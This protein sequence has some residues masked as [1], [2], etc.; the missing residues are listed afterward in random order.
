[1]AIIYTYPITELLTTDDTV[2]ITDSSSTNKA[3]R[4]ATIGQINALGPQGDITNV[5]LTMPDGFT[6]TPNKSNGVVTLDVT[7]RPAGLGP[8]GTGSQ[9]QFAAADPPGS[10][11]FVFD[12][13]PGL[14]VDISTTRTRLDVG[15]RLNPTGRGEINIHSGERNI[16]YT[17]GGVLDLEYAYPTSQPVFQN[18]LATAFVGL[19]G[20]EYDDNLVP[21]DPLA[22]Y[23][24][25][26]YNIQLPVVT[27]A[28]NTQTNYTDAR[29]LVV[30]ATTT[31][32][33]PVHQSKWISPIDSITEKIN[34]PGHSPGGR[35]QLTIG[36]PALT[37]NEP[38]G[39]I[40]LNG[41]NNSDEGGIIRLASA[42]NNTVGIAGPQ[43]SPSP[44]TDYNYDFSLPTKSPEQTDVV[45]NQGVR[46]VQV[47]AG[48][49]E[50]VVGTGRISTS[51]GTGSGCTINI[52]GVDTGI[53]TSVSIVQ[54]GEGYSEGDILT[55]DLPNHPGDAATIEVI[56]INGYKNK[57]LVASEERAFGPSQDKLYET[58]WVDPMEL[59][60]TGTPA[61]IAT[62]IQ[63]NAGNDQFGASSEFTYLAG[64]AAEPAERIRLG[65]GGGGASGYPGRLEIFGENA[66]NG[67]AGAL[68]LYCTNSNH[69][70]QL[71]GMQHTNAVSYDI[72]FPTTGPANS[73]QILQTNAS[74]ELAW[75]NTPS[76]G[77][78]TVEK[79][80][81]N[82]V[83][84]V[85]TINFTGGGVSVGDAGNGK[86]NVEVLPRLSQGWS[87]FPI[88]Q[89]E[90]FITVPS[91]ESKTFIQQTVCDVAAGVMEAIKIYKTGGDVQTVVSA[92]VYL[93]K[94]RDAAN[95][96]LKAYGTK[97]DSGG[98][99]G[100][101][102]IKLDDATNNNPPPATLNDWSPV[103][104]TPCIVVI[105]VDNSLAD[106]NVQ[107]LGKTGITIQDFNLRAQVISNKSE[108]DATNTVID[109]PVEDLKS[110]ANKEAGTDIVCCHF[111]PFHQQ[112]GQ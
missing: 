110:W 71:N 17:Q 3:T 84:P 38:Y 9:I 6:V 31:G 81:L 19:I 52:T 68:R 7:G 32:A 20:P 21:G 37:P 53:I 74:G 56:A 35:L 94:M 69:Y 67:P 64:T 89:G 55:I 77:S 40:L 80:A 101:T 22:S 72:T 98:L 27:P 73:N 70:V 66:T 24:L 109:Q 48:G 18:T 12:A 76:G 99:D 96:T 65:A 60:V 106:V 92:A 29:L 86:V 91:G 39:S 26:G 102:A 79:D 10:T 46:T 63:Y 93:G 47:D 41:G 1:M 95:T 5:V 61:G 44:V 82:P 88:Y 16:G 87:P 58:R 90:D 49:T 14:S 50:Y 33:D 108:F 104:G 51:G 4:T 42:I 13:D 59:G 112:P 57:V 43:L 103:A 100:I 107:L 83:T 8:A 11:N 54:S 105:E 97:T 111:D 62:Q 75:I 85:D 2:V 30:N 15:H 25:Q 78:I 36:S 28:D 34:E 45:F 23:N